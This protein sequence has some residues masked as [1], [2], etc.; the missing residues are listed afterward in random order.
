ME[1]EKKPPKKAAALGKLLKD[2]AS[3]RKFRDD[4]SAAVADAGLTGEV[5]DHLT[6]LQP[7]QRDVLIE[8][9]DVMARA[10]LKHDVEGAS[11]SFL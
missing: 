2:D 3:K 4:P 1:A 7:E 10:G 8:T 6:G 9:W 5:A 11:V